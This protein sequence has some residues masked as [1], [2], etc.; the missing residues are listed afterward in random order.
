VDVD[1]ATTIALETDGEVVGS[2]RS[3]ASA[4]LA[5]MLR[6]TR[7]TGARKPVPGETSYKP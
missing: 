7:T 4:K 2:W 6:I 3:G 5:M 1:G